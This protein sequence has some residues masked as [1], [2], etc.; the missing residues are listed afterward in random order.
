MTEFVLGNIFVRTN[1][2]GA[3]S[4]APGTVIPGHTHHFDHVALFFNGRWRVTKG[5]TELEKDGP[6]FLLIDKDFFHE[7]TYLDSNTEPGIS[8]CVWSHRTPDGEVSETWT[9][10]EEAYALKEEAV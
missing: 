8:W 10:W 6:F 5:T 1:G 3:Q 7:F 4:V 2:G 9:G